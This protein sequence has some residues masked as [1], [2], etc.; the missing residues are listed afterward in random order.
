MFPFPSAIVPLL[1]RVSQSPQP[2]AM[3]VGKQEEEGVCLER[4]TPA[5]DAART[6]RTTMRPYTVRV[7]V[8]AGT[9]GSAQA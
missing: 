1:N 2:Q 6:S 4:S 3:R 9:T 8:N 7:G 5:V